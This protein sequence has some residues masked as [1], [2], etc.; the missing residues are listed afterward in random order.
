MLWQKIEAGLSGVIDRKV[1][2]RKEF[3]DIDLLGP[4]VQVS[5]GEVSN[6][7]RSRP[8]MRLTVS[9]LYPKHTYKLSNS[10]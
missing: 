5:G 3:E 2:A 6:A 8:L 9:F 1:K 10:R 7:G 4:V